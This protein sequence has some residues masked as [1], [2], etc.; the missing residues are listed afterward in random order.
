MA[1]TGACIGRGSGFGS[2]NPPKLAGIGAVASRV[3]GRAAPDHA[4]SVSKLFVH[5]A[6]KGLQL[7]R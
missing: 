2:L 6:K 7:L 1:F 3:V 5:R 4:R